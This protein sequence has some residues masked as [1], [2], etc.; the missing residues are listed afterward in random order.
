MSTLILRNS[1]SNNYNNN[2]NNSCDKANTSVHYQLF[3]HKEELRRR[4]ADQV[5]IA[6]SKINLTQ[7]H[8]KDNMERVTDSDA[9]Q[10]RIAKSK[11]NLTESLIKDNMENV[12]DCSMET[13]EIIHR[14]MSF[15][16]HLQSQLVRFVLLVKMGFMRSIGNGPT[17]SKKRVH[18][19]E[20]Q[21]R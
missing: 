18:P 20:K 10:I 1:N 12:T 8:I 13:L 2:A 15:Q 9:G 7:S 16:K 21:R 4:E 5:R 19:K 3:M 14:E 11:I 17:T 6:K